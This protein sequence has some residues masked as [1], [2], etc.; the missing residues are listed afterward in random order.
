MVKFRTIRGFLAAL[1]VAAA[2]TTVL[3]AQFPDSAKLLAAQREALKKLANMDG[4]WR[5]EAWTLFPTGEKHVITRVGDTD[6]P[7]AGAVSPQ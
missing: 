7:S 2:L 5:G 4:V 6:W 3:P 1:T